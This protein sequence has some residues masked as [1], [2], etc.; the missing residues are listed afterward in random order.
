MKR[1]ESGIRISCLNQ[2]G[3]GDFC[4]T[5]SFCAFISL[6][7]RTNV[8]FGSGA[9]DDDDDD[10]DDGFVVILLRLW[11]GEDGEAAVREEE[12]EEERVEEVEE[13]KV[14]EDEGEEELFSSEV[15]VGITS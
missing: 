1:S 6:L 13:E 8:V 2:V 9:P 10:D 3:K 11:L 15:P 12:E 4:P 7:F 5:R 14:E